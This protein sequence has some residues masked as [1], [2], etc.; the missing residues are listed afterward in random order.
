[1][2]LKKSSLESVARGARHNS[3]Y[4]NVKFNGHHGTGKQRAPRTAV[5]DANRHSS[6]IASVEKRPRSYAEM[7]ADYSEAIRQASAAAVRN[8][9]FSFSNVV[10]NSPFGTFTTP[11]LSRKMISIAKR[12]GASGKGQKNDLSFS[13]PFNSLDR[14]VRCDN[15]NTAEHHD[16]QRHETTKQKHDRAITVDSKS[17]DRSY[18][19]LVADCSKSVHNIFLASNGALVPRLNVLA[20][21][22]LESFVAPARNASSTNNLQA[23]PRQTNRSVSETSSSSARQSSTQVSTST[24]ASKQPQVELHMVPSA[25]ESVVSINVDSV[26]AR[27]SNALN[28][29]SEEL[30][31]VVRSNQKPTE[32]PWNAA[33]IRQSANSAS[34]HGDFGP[35]RISISEDS[36]PIKQIEFSINGKPVSELKSI[37]ARTERLDVVTSSDKI[38]IRVPFAKDDVSTTSRS[39]RAVDEPRK[40]S[41]SMEQILNVQISANFQ[42]EPTKGSAERSRNTAKTGTTSTPPPSSSSSRTPATRALLKDHPAKVSSSVFD[43][44]RRR[45]TSARTDIKPDDAIKKR[46]NERKVSSG[47]RD[48][49][50]QREAP[51]KLPA[52]E[53]E[54]DAE[55]GGLNAK[56]TTNPETSKYDKIEPS[57]PRV[58]SDMIPWWSSSDSFNKMKKKEKEDNRKSSRS[59]WTETTL[60]DAVAT[61]NNSSDTMSHWNFQEQR[62]EFK[63]TVHYPS[64]FRLKPNRENLDATSEV[65][66]NDLKIDNMQTQVMEKDDEKISDNERTKP[67]TPETTNVQSKYNANGEPDMHAKKASILRRKFKESKDTQDSPLKPDREKKSYYP[68]KEINAIDDTLTSNEKVNNILDA[69]KPIEKR[70]DGTLIDYGLKVSSRKPTMKLDSGATEIGNPSPTVMKTQDLTSKKSVNEMAPKTEKMSKT[71]T[72][73]RMESDKAEKLEAK[74][75]FSKEKD[76]LIMKDLTTS[77]DVKVREKNH[78]TKEDFEQGGPKRLSSISAP[79]ETEFQKSEKSNLRSFQSNDTRHLPKV[80]MAKKMTQRKKSPLIT[81]NTTKSSSQ[82]KSNLVL[83][84]KDHVPFKD[85]IDKNSGM[86]PF[87]RRSADKLA[88][89][90]DVGK[91]AV[92]IS[93]QSSA[94]GD[95]SSKNRQENRS[96]KSKSAQDKRNSEESSDPP[97][98]SGGSAGFKS[99]D[100]KIRTR[101]E[102]RFSESHANFHRCQPSAIGSI[103]PWA[104]MDR[105]EKSVLYSAWLQRFRNDVD[106]HEKFF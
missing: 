80:P 1:M 31:V 93:K 49:K 32:A 42:N 47:S 10:R 52:N 44:A 71:A 105:P 86:T 79:K 104:Q 65:R 55:A 8:D 14:S 61:T 7:I 84:T 59:D 60:P 91:A 56:E 58:H 37:V 36:A 9:N 45:A 70:K 20:K 100:S 75:I 40:R 66:K 101:T 54:N 82:T 30:S 88:E 5:N 63:P 12:S 73:K 34:R 39:S 94:N 77:T 106:D 25:K 62:E 92:E 46:L 41:D 76:N 35:M 98:K 72:I 6:F 51:R 90:I 38:E 78:I 21:S 23:T 96:R 26:S 16:S 29:T 11:P 13:D 2:S 83:K 102:V 103:A 3:T 17:E 18:A 95:L 69:I 87:T 67:V 15:T 97:K 74:R 19:K 85:S 68:S 89:T 27:L 4:R 28:L 81:T 57:D 50:I 53:E 64:L 33:T 24:G 22:S 99:A 43:D 48:S